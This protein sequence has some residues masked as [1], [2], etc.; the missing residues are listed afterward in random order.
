MLGDLGSGLSSTAALP[1]GFAYSHSTLLYLSFPIYETGV[2]VL[3]YLT[4]AWL[5]Q[6]FGKCAMISVWEM[7]CDCSVN[8]KAR[9]CPVPLFGRLCMQGL[10]LL[11]PYQIDLNGGIQ[12]EQCD[13]VFL[14][15]LGL[16]RTSPV[17]FSQLT[18]DES[19][20]DSRY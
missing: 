3:P 10:L 7:P 12:N 19:S 16:A 4:K 17:T 8:L 20:S 18:A 6:L 2:I 11:A 13:W 5:N 15:Q 1:C 9:Q 14:Q